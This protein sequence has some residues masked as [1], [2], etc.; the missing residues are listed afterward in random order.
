MRRV[1]PLLER[2][3][4]D[5]EVWAPLPSPVAGELAAEGRVLHGA[6][7]LLRYSP[8]ALR[9]APGPGARLASVPG[10]LRRFAALLR[11]ERFD[12]VHLNT[13][14]T[15]PEA[16]AARRVG[17]PALVHAHEILPGGRR[18]GLTAAALRGTAGLTIAVSEAAARPLE[19]RGVRVRVVANGVELGRPVARPASSFVAGAVGTVSRRKGSDLVLGVGRALEGRVELRLIGP[20]AP[21]PEAGWAEE[22]L[23]SA[24][25]AGVTYAGASAD[26]LAGLHA[27]LMPSRE[28]PFPLAVL[29]AMAAGL[30]VVGAAVDG[31]PEQLADG[32]GI[33]VPPEDV[34][35]M[36]GALL[37]LADDPERC[38]RIGTA[39]RERVAERFTLERQ[40]EGLAAAYAE[41]IDRAYGAK[42]L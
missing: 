17:I 31:I 1:L 26:P 29:E 40:A 13:L 33:L 14:L 15:L 37:A 9:E 20:P 42:R 22:V 19:A 39:A 32:A 10:Y 2:R 6:P 27:L 41:A 12:V 36:A 18:G 11:R 24:P 23:R 38:R 8:A 3:G 7:R 25:A 35:G 4:F 5:F 30:P 16:M 21:G 34:A 28:D